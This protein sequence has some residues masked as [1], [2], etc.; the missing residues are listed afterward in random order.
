[1]KKQQLESEGISKEE[2]A[3]LKKEIQLK[4]D[5]KNSAMDNPQT[6]QQNAL[7]KTE[8][9]EISLTHAFDATKETAG[10]G[11]EKP[12]QP[13]SSHV[14]AEKDQLPSNPKHKH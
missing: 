1:M 9:C 14:E 13:V 4:E 6:F 5:Q 3:Q 2:K 7:H 11:N 10:K 8:E 12:V